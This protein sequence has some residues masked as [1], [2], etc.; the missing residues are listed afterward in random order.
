MI[1]QVA[2][3]M[4]YMEKKLHHAVS[5]SF[6]GSKMGVGLVLIRYVIIVSYDTVSQGRLEFTASDSMRITYCTSNIDDVYA[7]SLVIRQF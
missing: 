7:P 3:L 5:L 6:C 1:L 4:R 2:L